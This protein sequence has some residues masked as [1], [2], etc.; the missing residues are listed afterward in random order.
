MLSA[1][2]A[3]MTSKKYSKNTWPHPA[4]RNQAIFFQK[5]RHVSKRSLSKKLPRAFG[6]TDN[7][8]LWTGSENTIRTFSPP[9]QT[10]VLQNPSILA[11]HYSYSR[12]HRHR[13]LQHFDLKIN[14]RIGRTCRLYHF[15]DVATAHC[16][17]PVMWDLYY[18]LIQ[19][20]WAGL[21]ADPVAQSKVC[22]GK[23]RTRRGRE[24]NNDLR[25]NDTWQCVIDGKVSSA[26]SERT[27]EVC[28]I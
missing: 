19:V 6:A 25:G 1:H 5:V 23:E 16:G 10:R 12:K 26:E 7:E 3:M 21:I 28:N 17:P 18:S 15:D 24:S 22:R 11:H 14:Y 9:I 13:H 20:V 27:T 2:A 8:V 4:R